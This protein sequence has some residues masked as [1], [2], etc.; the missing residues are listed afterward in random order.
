ML[1]SYLIRYQ[2]ILRDQFWFA[3]LC[4]VAVCRLPDKALYDTLH[5][6]LEV[7]AKSTIL[8]FPRTSHL[9]IIFHSF[10]PHLYSE[11]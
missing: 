8:F 10:L 5:I 11:A 7:I 9:A 3:I 4:A 1:T 2:N 6:C